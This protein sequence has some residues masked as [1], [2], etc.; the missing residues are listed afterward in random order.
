[1]SAAQGALVTAEATLERARA[2]F[3]GQAPAPALQV[4]IDEALLRVLSD[5]GKHERVFEV[6]QVLLATLARAGAPPIRAANVHLNIAHAAV[7]GARLEEAGQHLEQAR[8]LDVAG[9]LEARI[10]ALAAHV[11]ID[12]RRIEDAERLARAALATAERIGEMDVACEALIVLGRLAR[13]GDLDRAEEA[14]VR[15]HALAEQHGLAVWR[16]RALHE[17][18]TIDMFRDNSPLRLI[19][20]RELA[21]DLGALATVAS[22][23]IELTAVY[24][25]RFELE[26]SLE[27]ALRALDA[28]RRYRLMGVASI[29]LLFIA[30]LHGLRRDRAGM[31]RQ[32]AELPVVTGDEAV[33]FDMCRNAFRAEASL[34][35]GNLKQARRDLAASVGFGRRLSAGAPSPT[36]GEWTLMWTLE[37]PEG[38]AAEA[39]A[40]PEWAMVQP[41]NRGFVHYATAVSFGRRGLVVDAAESVVLGDLILAHA[42]WYWHHIASLMDKLDVHSRTQ[43]AAIAVAK[44]GSAAMR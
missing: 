6:G 2:S 22:V 14:F 32:L 26:R 39:Q 3:D 5:A 38:A 44:T 15:A 28:G 9:A 35:E 12:D 16:S 36:F 30:E 34:C 13:A 18:G 31:E 20:A 33:Y 23:D 37:H 27:A 11:A 25:L 1:V 4:E 8:Q 43:L 10:G 42:P 19:E 29:A 17:L 40:P 24:A 7:A 41:I 21:A